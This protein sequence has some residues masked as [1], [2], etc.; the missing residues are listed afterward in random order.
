MDCI[1]V[2]RGKHDVFVEVKHCQWGDNAQEEWNS[3]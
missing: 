3:F 2:H 1:E